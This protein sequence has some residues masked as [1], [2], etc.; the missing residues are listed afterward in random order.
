MDIVMVRVDERL[1]H[2]QI[3]NIWYAKSNIS[4]IL[5]VDKELVEDQFMTNVYKALAPLSIHVDVVAVDG[6]LNFLNENSLREGRI[7]LLSR[8]LAPIVELAGRCDLP[9]QVFLVDKKYFPNKI[10]ISEEDK[11]CLRRLVEFGITA[12]AQEYPEDEPFIVN[13][14]YRST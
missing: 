2:G 10:P 13:P 6:A 14:F 9:G 5:I 3:M 12:I 8:T 1:I 7:L 11:H 4:H